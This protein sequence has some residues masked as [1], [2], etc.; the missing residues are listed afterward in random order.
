MLATAT[1]QVSGAPAFGT[2]MGQP[3][4]AL[5]PVKAG[6]DIV[7]S[8]H[9][10][11]SNPAFSHYYAVATPVSGLCQIWA[12]TDDLIT[13]AMLDATFVRLRKALS[14]NYGTAETTEPASAEAFLHGG[15][16]SSDAAWR[17]HLPLRLRSISLEREGADTDKPK[18]LRLR[19]TFANIAKCLNWAPGQSM[20]GL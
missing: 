17:N 13:T 9:P 12:E 6:R 8:V 20:A 1:T 2:R 4:R 18:V 10:P 7:F 19:Y 3:L 5:K 16:G 11:Q 15:L 14:Q